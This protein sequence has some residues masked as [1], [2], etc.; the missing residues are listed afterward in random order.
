MNL[1][2]RRKMLHGFT[3]A[4]RSLRRSGRLRRMQ[5]LVDAIALEFGVDGFGEFGLREADGLGTLDFE[6]PLK[7]RRREM[8]HHRIMFEVR[9][10]FF[11]VVGDDVRGDKRQMQMAFAPAQRFAP[12]QQQLGLHRQRKQLFDQRGWRFTAHHATF[13]LTLWPLISARLSLA[14]MPLTCSLAT[15][16]NECRSRTS[17]VPPT[18]PG[19]PVSPATEFTKSIGATP[20]SLPT[21]IQRRVWPSGVA[22]LTLGLG[23]AAG[24]DLA[25]MNNFD[26]GFGSGAFTEARISAS[27][28]VFAASAFT[29]TSGLA[30]SGGIIFFTGAADA[31]FHGVVLNFNGAANFD[32]ARCGRSLNCRGRSSRRL[33]KLGRRSSRSRKFPRV[34]RSSQEAGRSRR[35][36]FSSRCGGRS[37]S[38]VL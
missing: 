36:K 26:S 18:L 13:T 11:A 8:L 9:Q 34:P 25:L 23:A 3:R 22:R 4:G 24:T 17:T 30:A 33:S 19:N 38:S 28:K 2:L 1:M 6:Q 12:D 5:R 14:T 16:T 29:S 7:I 21:L 10:H 32:S 31:A 20:C 27:E 37:Y 35:S 15:S